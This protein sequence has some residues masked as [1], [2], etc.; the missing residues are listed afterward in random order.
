MK[1][2]ALLLTIIFLF[3]FALNLIAL[4]QH[5]A[6]NSEHLTMQQLDTSRYFSPF[7]LPFVPHNHKQFKKLLMILNTCAKNEHLNYMEKHA[8]AGYQLKN[9]KLDYAHQLYQQNFYIYNLSN[10]EFLRNFGEFSTSKTKHSYSYTYQSPA[11]YQV[12]LEPI[13]HALHSDANFE[14]VFFLETLDQSKYRNFLTQIN[15]QINQNFKTNYSINDYLLN[16]SLELLLPE[17]DLDPNLVE[18]IN[19]LEVFLLVSLLLYFI[20][21]QNNISL[22]KLNG[23]SFGKTFVSLAL[24]PLGLILLAIISVDFLAILQGIKLTDLT[25]KQLFMLFVMVL[26]ALFTVAIMYAISLARVKE[27]IFNITTFW[28][29]GVTKLLLITTVIVSLA[30]LGQLLFSSYNFVN[31]RHAELSNY[32]E[33]FPQLVGSNRPDITNY[34]AKMQVYRQADQSDALYINDSG[35]SYVQPKDVPR[36]ITAVELNLNYLKLHPIKDIHRKKIKISSHERRTI[37]IIPLTKKHFLTATLKFQREIS[38][39]A[40]KNG[41]LVIYSDPKYNQHLTDIISKKNISN[42]IIQVFTPNNIGNYQGKDDTILHVLSGFDED[43][44]LLPLNGSVAKMNKHWQPILHQ[45][46]LSDN[47]PQ[48]IRYDKAELEDL[49]MALG[50]VIGEALIQLLLLATVFMISFYSMLSFFTKNL[51][52]IGLKNAFGYSRLRNYWGYWA[53]MALQ[54]ALAALFSIDPELHIAREIYF[55]LVGLCAVIEIILMNHFINYLERKAIQ[56]VK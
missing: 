8:Y 26:L 38:K 11:D 10:T 3:T 12:T 29:L 44:L 33:F 4:N 13:S 20:L 9:G 42:E 50:N 51:Y 23:W 36:A 16:S 52:A 5:S 39:N 56:N 7:K 17:F 46:N 45:Q 27:K 32:V 18:L 54:Y 24:A 41:I 6:K 1:H 22:Y 53:L 30:P 15:Q 49:K 21:Q 2:K 35:S 48:L 19:Y 55:I 34:K 47:F 37:L 40:Q 14:G 31:S 28:L 25:F 43:R